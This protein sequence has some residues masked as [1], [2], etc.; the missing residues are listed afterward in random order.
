MSC[1]V[2]MLRMQ[3]DGLIELP[4]PTR[5]RPAS[6]KVIGTPESDPQPDLVCSLSELAQLGLVLVRGGP[7]L[8]RWNEFVS[9]HH[10]LS[11]K[12]LPGAQLRYLIM[13]GERVLGA[14]GF[15]AAAWKVAPRDDYIGWSPEQREA[16]L[17]LIVGQSRFLILPWIR[18][19]NLA[20][21]TLAM[22]TERL[23]RDWQ[24][25]Y[26]FQP[27]LME[28]FVDNTRFLGTSYK[29]SNWLNVGN[30]KGRGKLDRYNKW[31]QPVKSIWLRP[32]VKNF[33]ER[34]RGAGG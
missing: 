9:R 27:A 23:P 14:M 15:G 16:G 4:P 30:T 10:Y 31:D 1:R 17:H 13:D 12:M 3:R 20:S 34:L 6:Y 19:Q 5:E 29:A 26:G 32:L 22:A 25:H 33:R 28:S 2:A 21:K 8:T 18:C 7:Q 24:E 11:Y